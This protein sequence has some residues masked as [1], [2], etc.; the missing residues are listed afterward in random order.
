MLSIV[1][2]FKIRIRRDNFASIYVYLYLYGLNPG[3][4]I[5]NGKAFPIGSA[6]AHNYMKIQS[7][8]PLEAGVHHTP[9][10]VKVK[11]IK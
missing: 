5:Y 11:L 7:D 3:F 2:Q 1:K 6:T 4:N 9:Y 8:Q 10:A